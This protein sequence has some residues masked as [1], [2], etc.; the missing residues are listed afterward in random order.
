M[1]FLSFQTNTLV[2]NFKSE[3]LHDVNESKRLENWK[4]DTQFVQDSVI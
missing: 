1:E 3:L 2:L 4:L